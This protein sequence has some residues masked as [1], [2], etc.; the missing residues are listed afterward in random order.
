MP[1]HLAVL[2]RGLNTIGQAS[3]GHEKKQGF[4][5]LRIF[6]YRPDIGVPYGKLRWLNIRRFPVGGFFCAQPTGEQ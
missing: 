3:L 2:S 6:N 4:I 5:D 1:L